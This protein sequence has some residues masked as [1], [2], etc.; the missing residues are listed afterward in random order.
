VKVAFIGVTTQETPVITIAAATEGLCFKDPAESILHYYD[1]MKAQA[2]V[3]V[4]LSHLGFSDGGYGYGLPIY[5]DQVLAQK[6]ITAGKPANL[7]IGG[8]SHSNLTAATVVGGKTTVAQAYYNGRAVGRADVT[9]GTDGAV[10]VALDL[11]AGPHRVTDPSTRQ[12]RPDRV[13]P[14]IPRTSPDQ[15]EIGWTNGPI[16]RNY[17]GDSLMGAF[18]NDAIYGELNSDA[19][20]A[21]DVEIVFNNPGGLRADI[22]CA[23]YPC[24]MTYG[25]LFSVL[26]FGNATAV[27]TMTGDRILELINQSASLNKGALQV[28][29]LRYKFYNYRVDTNPDPP[30]S[31]KSWSTGRVGRVR[32]AVRRLLRPARADRTYKV[33]ANGSSPRPGQ[34]LRLQVHEGHHV[35]GRHAQPGECL[36]GQDVHGR[37]PVQRGA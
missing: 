19:T 10:G 34:L 33:A 8:H 13:M 15:P 14:S 37:E 25:A 2:D 9:V 32:R 4:V 21:N 22:T 1:E 26:T 23:T 7:I 29:G 6:L 5:G 12:S 11:Q 36:G 35:L 31:T 16:T 24:V 18:V 28:S 27:G 3:V 20:A 30:P 17:D